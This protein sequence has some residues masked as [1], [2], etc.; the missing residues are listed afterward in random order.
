MDKKFFVKFLAKN[1]WFTST[2]MGVTI[3]LLNSI[4]C[5]C[6]T[7]THGI[8]AGPGSLFGTTSTRFSTTT[9][10]LPAI[11]RTVN[12]NRQL[13]IVKKS[14]IK[15]L[16]NYWFTSTTLVVAICLFNHI[17]C[18]CR[19]STFSILFGSASLFG[20]TSTSSGAT[21]PWLPIVP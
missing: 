8:I 15:L 6:C 4:A 2:T 12:W 5:T 16:R 9:P 11:P 1:T 14:L 17:S 18:T 7:S 3:R 10:W 13:E 21:A 19:P 20:T